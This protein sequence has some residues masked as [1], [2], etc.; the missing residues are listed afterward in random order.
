MIWLL[1][2]SILS[3]YVEKDKVMGIDKTWPARFSPSGIGHGSKFVNGLLSYIR[4]VKVK[5]KRTFSDQ[6]L[7]WKTDSICRGKELENKMQL[8]KEMDLWK[9]RS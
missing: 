3:Q 8:Y 7:L 5:M 4:M 9:R 2:T 1:K 6:M